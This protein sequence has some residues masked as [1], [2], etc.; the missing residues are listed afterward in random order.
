MALTGPGSLFQA[1]WNP[2]GHF[3]A[4]SHGKNQLP[5]PLGLFGRPGG[6]GTGNESR[7]TTISEPWAGQM[8]YLLDV[9]QQA[10]NQYNSAGPSYFP[11][12]TVTGPG[13]STLYGQDYAMNLARSQLP[14]FGAAG[15]NS[16]MFNLGPAR[17]LSTNPYLQ[18]A[19]LAAQNPL[20]T[21][22]TEAGGPLSAIRSGF[23]AGAPD[24]VSTR[25]GIAEGIAMRG[26]GQQ[27]SD[28]SSTMALQGY[29]QAQNNAVQTLGMM[30]QLMES[31]A[32]PSFLASSVGQQ[33]DAYTQAILNDQIQ[34]WN[35]EQNLPAQKLAQ[36][37]GLIQGN[38]GGTADSTG[39]TP[40]PQGN[41]IM[42]GLGG[43]AA[44]FSVGGPWGGVI[45]GILGMLGS[46]SPGQGGIFAR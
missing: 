18:N 26:L 17:D 32:Y 13:A 44:G 37:Q 5:D 25:Q 27:L 28:I 42:G 29:N 16:A 1:A 9:F 30:P 19:I 7:L 35:Y 12:S 22:F 46:R 23:M 36:Y 31:Q 4:A 24:G 33:Q 15:M 10:Q 41:P 11:G 21:R 45:G 20:I 6:A 40:L 34:R 38:Y 8:P 2:V 39:T 43:A 3:D 14:G